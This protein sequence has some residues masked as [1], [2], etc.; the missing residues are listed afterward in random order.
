MP[1]RLALVT[2]ATFM[3]ACYSRDPRAETGTGASVPGSGCPLVVEVDNLGL[4]P[5]LVSWIEVDTKMTFRIG[6]ADHGETVLP[7]PEHVRVRMQKYRGRY[8]VKSFSLERSNGSRPNYRLHQR[9]ADPY[10]MGVPNT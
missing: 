8:E 7:V 5:L 3:L 9:C 6:Q 1:A 4:D 2:A 10:E